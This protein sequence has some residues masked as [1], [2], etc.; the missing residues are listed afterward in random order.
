VTTQ[1][2]KDTRV[3]RDA[4]SVSCPRVGSDTNGLHCLVDY[5]RVYIKDHRYDHRLALDKHEAAALRDWLNE[6]LS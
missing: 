3:F 2:T 1:P 4:T 5:D 6:V